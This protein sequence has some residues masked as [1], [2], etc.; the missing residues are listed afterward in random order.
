MDRQ[1]IAA[2]PPQALARLINGSLVHA[3]LWIARDQAPAERLDEA[4]AA[5]ELM[6]RGLLL[7]PRT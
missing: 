6:L 1:T 7:A 4:L 2:A 5:L 3:A